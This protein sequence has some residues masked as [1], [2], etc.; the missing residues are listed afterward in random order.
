MGDWGHSHWSTWVTRVGLA[1]DVGRERADGRDGG[2]I[3]GLGGE[4]GHDGETGGGRGCMRERE[5]GIYRWWRRVELGI[6][7]CAVGPGLQ[8]SV[9]VNASS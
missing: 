1:D 3:G 2:R 6:V 4:F 5:A 7:K 9:G 8:A